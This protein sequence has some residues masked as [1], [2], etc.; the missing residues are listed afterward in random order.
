MSVPKFERPENMAEYLYQYLRVAGRIARSAGLFIGLK[1]AD[2]TVGE[3]QRRQFEQKIARGETI[4]I[5]DIPKPPG[6]ET[7]RI[8]GLRD[9]KADISPGAEFPKRKSRFLKAESYPEPV[10]PFAYRNPPTSAM[11]ISGLGETKK[12]RPY[13][14]FFGFKL[15]WGGLHQM[16]VVNGAPRSIMKQIASIFW[17]DW[18]RVGVV[19]RKQQTVTDTAAMSEEIKAVAKE[20][21]AALVGIT[22]PTDEMFFEGFEPSYKYAISVAVP[23]NREEMSHTPS[24]RSHLEV[25]RIYRDVGQVAT[26]LAEHNPCPRL[27]CK[28]LHQHRP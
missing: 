1:L 22:E 21:G 23:M 6:S 16:L 26:R 11:V 24:E 19:A 2:R 14:L 12:R 25:F 18:R 9:V 13:H 20:H 15:I 5:D 28:G 17:E 8:E 7:Q 10:Y 4:W 27:S 3:W